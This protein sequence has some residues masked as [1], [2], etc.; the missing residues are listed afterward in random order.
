MFE[1][2]WSTELNR[3]GYSAPEA[4][5]AEAERHINLRKLNLFIGPNNSGKSR[6]ARTLISSTEESLI[7]ETPNLLIKSIHKTLAAEN[8][9]RN[10]EI[11]NTIIEAAQAK[12][13]SRA[14]TKEHIKALLN[15]AKTI[16]NHNTSSDYLEFFR[17]LIRADG[18]SD[19][20]RQAI[21]E[22]SDIKITQHNQYYIPIL[23]GMRPL[24]NHKQHTDHYR[25]RTI[26]DYFN[27]N[28]TDEIKI[29]T[30]QHLYE[31]L[32]RNLLGQPDERKKIREYEYLLGQEFFNNVEVTLIPEYGKD[33]VAVKIGN[34]AQFP[35]YHLGDG[36]QQVIII[37]SAA[38][39]EQEES[40]FCIEEPETSMHPG[41][42]RQLALFLLEHTPHQ[43]LMTTHSNHLL[44]LAET[45]DDVL[46]HRVSKSVDDKGTP[47]F[48]IRECTATDRDILLDLGVRA[49]SVYLANCTIWVE[50]ISD[51]LYLRCWMEKYIQELPDGD[52]KTKLS[53]LME[54]Y[55]YA[56]VEYQGGTLGHWD[57]ANDD[58]DGDLDKGLAAIRACSGPL[59]IADGD[60]RGKGER[61]EHLAQQLGDCLEVLPGKEI[62]NLIP[63]KVLHATAKAFFEQRRT[64]K[65]GLD[66]AQVDG[67]KYD[68]YSKSVKGIGRLLDDQ[69]G[70]SKTG[71]DKRQVFAE[72]S[73]T[74]RDKVKFC[75]MAVQQMRKDADWQLTPEL[76]SLCQR[77]YAH[78]L[79]H[80][81]N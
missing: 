42:L 68:N 21:Q 27:E 4:G 74:I 55:H 69:L 37:T 16:A 80:N 67:L 31:L 30:G 18:L 28:L 49:S 48:L 22:A 17:R 32:T 8:T 23:R 56:F 45:R 29:I 11:P 19:T 7:A 73:G 66:I 53:G 12:L 38:F 64:D 58:V 77:I 40:L 20:L 10:I 52:E 6:A 57:F 24:D 79:K 14:T 44:D 70:L 33:T 26:T 9:P 62:E 81:Q 61:A 13:A 43:Y 51:R 2:I 75:R 41:M 65:K 71:K 54:N 15:H 72:G 34:E 25:D 5:T 3:L 59:V 78:I 39:L 63:E 47:S 50:G 35:I 76:T 1:K 60:I 46:I 36:L